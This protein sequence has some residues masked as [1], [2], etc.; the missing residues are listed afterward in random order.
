MARRK[1]N[2]FV[3]FFENIFQICPNVRQKDK[4]KEE[5]VKIEKEEV[6]VSEV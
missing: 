5:E 6:K 4:K 3:K 1:K 2:I